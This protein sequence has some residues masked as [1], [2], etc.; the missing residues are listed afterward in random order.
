MTLLHTLEQGL[1]EIDARGLRR[2]RRTADTP[3]SAHMQVDGRATIGFA[4]NDYLGLAAHPLVRNLRQ[5][6]TILAFDVAL[7]DP[8]RAAT[9]SRRFF[10]HALQ[11]ELLLRPIGTTVY[12]MPPY[13]LDNEMQAFLAT[14]TRETF[15]ATVAE[16]L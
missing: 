9:F 11:R 14:R 1:R 15:D 3:C 10:E 8:Q 13:I 2:R 5:S 7:K 4:S 16:D 12:V 6:G